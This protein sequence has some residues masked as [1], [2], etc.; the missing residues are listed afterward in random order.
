M[1]D[2]VQTR[3]KI[4]GRVGQVKFVASRDRFFDALVLH[5]RLKRRVKMLADRL[6]LFV[7]ADY[8]LD[9]L[10]VL[11]Q[12]TR[13]RSTPL[14][15]RKRSTSLLDFSK[16][17]R[18]FRRPSSRYSIDWRTL[19]YTSDRLQ[20]ASFSLYLKTATR[21]QKRVSTRSKIFKFFGPQNVV[22]LS[23]K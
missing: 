22:T 1:A 15:T 5:E 7:L 6:V 4:G 2:S 16:A 3:Q 20:S 10:C 9:E 14:R 12:A 19:T 18:S 23:T 13:Q 11:L 17:I 21:M 8:S